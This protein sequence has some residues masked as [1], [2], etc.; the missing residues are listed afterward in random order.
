[1]PAGLHAP[2]EDSPAR[3]S[4][5]TVAGTAALQASALETDCGK[6]ITASQ[7]RPDSGWCYPRVLAHT[8]T[9]LP[10]I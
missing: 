10:F 6:R 3:F 5:F 7:G 9:L 8:N 2:A 4:M 1:M